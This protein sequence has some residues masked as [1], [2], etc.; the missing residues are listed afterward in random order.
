M[1]NH[2]TVMRF[3]FLADLYIFTRLEI[4]SYYRDPFFFRSMY[5]EKIISFGFCDIRNNQGYQPRLRQITF[6]STLIILIQ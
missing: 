3:V 2:V 4:P 1:G 5:Y 6:T